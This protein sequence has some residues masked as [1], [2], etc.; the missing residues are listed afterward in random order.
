VSRR[1]EDYAMIGDLQTAALVERGGSIDWLCFP[2]FDSGACFASLLGT[3]E[4]GRWLVAPVEGGKTTRR[5]LHG[6]FV[7]ETTWECE[8]GVV[9]VLDFM[10][11][12]G[13]APD[14]VRIVEGVKGRV[15]MRSEL[16]IRFDYGKIVP[17]VRRED[18]A[19]LAIA[20]PDGLC[21]RTP[22]HTYGENMRTVSTF[23]V[24]E[25]E[26]IPFVLTWF[27]SHGDA[28]AEIDPEVALSETETFWRE[29]NEACEVQLPP[30][31][32][33]VLQR[34]LM[35]LKALTYAPT[36]G[37]VAAPTTSLPERIGGVRNWDYRYCWLRDATLT[38]LSLLS[39]GYVEEAGQWRRW[40]LRAV[41][42]D[43]ADIQIMYSVAGD[44]RLTELELP[45]LQG[46]EGSAPVR[47]GNAASE[48]LQ[49]DVFGEVMDAFFLARAHGL[50]KEKSAWSLQKLLLS[51]LESVWFKPDQGIWEIRGERRHFVHSK[52]MAWVAFD[53]AVRSIETQGMDGPL[54]KWR[55]LRD[56][57]HEE[58][59]DR[60]F[61]EEL[62]SF[63]QSYG[64]KEL[65]ASLLMIPLVG[66]LPPSDPRVQG[67]VEAVERGL[68]EHGFVLRYRTHEDGVD[69]LPPGEGVF[70]PC[71][72][73]L[74]DCLE[75]LGRHD[76]AHALFDRLLSL[77]NDV[78]LLS[79]EYDPVAKRLLGNFPQAFTHLALVNSAFTVL[80]HL[81]SPRHPR[82]SGQ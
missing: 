3:P 61:D 41:A 13:K 38:L 10:P 43:P 48:Q 9:R 50:P 30:E 81:P 79:E 51:Y 60:G 53:R 33:D 5:Y 29:W 78:G 75:L 57:I 25:G 82:H 32:K 68:V 28:P 1:I 27:P 7:L 73:W 47:I 67:T 46:Y 2:R 56:T 36:G 24:D 21:F 8:D 49:I 23:A 64:S 42:G 39:A 18:H 59:C 17:W 19:R 66:F 11:P 54:E 20:G 44:R 55:S 45:W 76:D 16:V 6:T 58:V 74:V 15:Q 34:S 14:V 72:F 62:G 70:L 12:R 40:L 26:R 80:P 37:I 4:N 22:A 77:A 63:T 65:D 71:S 52:V 35:V 31:S 69:G